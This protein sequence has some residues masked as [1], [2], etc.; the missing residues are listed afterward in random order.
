MSRIFGGVETGGTWTVCAVGTGPDT[1]ERL[2]EFPT[3]SPSETLERV[4]AFFR[5]GRLPDALGVGSFGP[6]D[7]DPSSPTWGTVRN[8]PKPG[9]HGAVVAPLLR[10]QLEVPVAFDTD[11]AAAGLAEHRW[12]AGRDVA[13]LVYLTVGTGVGAGLIVNGRPLRGL[14]HPE[15]GHM[16]IPHDV[17][18]DPFPGAC[19][20]H[21]DC[22]EGLASG[23]A[24]A[25]R[26][27][28]RPEDLPADH[29]AW[30][31]EAKYLAAGLFNI[32]CVASPQRIIV[33]GG[34]IEHQL[35]AKVKQEMRHLNAGYLETPLLSEDLDS[36]VVEP[37]LGDRA[38]VLGAIALA[39]LAATR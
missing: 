33:G 16:R 38:G 22:W 30:S 26:W 25:K 11:V 20:V 24:I 7:L 37:R 17:R 19:P 12:G 31:L 27:G 35:L 32:V 8:T 39:E 28:T 2:E 14:V 15:A 9:W 34:V 4:V 3:T 21:G 10:D 6:I 18:A 29:P 13:D 1:I 5:S 23:P 36:Y